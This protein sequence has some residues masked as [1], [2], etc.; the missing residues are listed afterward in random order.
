MRA[1]MNGD[2]GAD[3][4]QVYVCVCNM[5]YLIPIILCDIHYPQRNVVQR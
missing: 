2:V 4:L 3:D 5:V 1:V